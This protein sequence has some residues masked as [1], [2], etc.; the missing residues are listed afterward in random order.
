MIKKSFKFLGNCPCVLERL[1]RKLDSEQ[2][3]QCVPL[4]GKETTLSQHYPDDMIK[5]IV[6]G[7]KQTAAQHDPERFHAF[8]TTSF[9]VMA[10][11]T[12]PDDWVPIFESAQKSFDMTRQRSYVLPTSD[13]TWKMVQQLV[14]WHQLERVQIAYQPTML[15]L[16]LHIPHTHRGWALLYN[17]QTVEVVEED[18][19]DVRH[20]RA[21][22]RKPVNIGIFF[23]GYATPSSHANQPVSARPDGQPLQEPAEDDPQAIVAHNTE[24]ITFPRMPGLSQDVKTL[25]SRLHRNLGHPHNNE[26]K[27]M[28]AMNGIKDQKVYDAV[29]ALTCE[30]CLRVRGPGKPEPA[31]IP[32]D[33]S[34]Q[35]GDVLQIDIVYVRD[36]TST[37]YIFLG[38]IDECTHLHMALHLNDRSPEE[39]HY[40]FS[41]FWARP[42]GFP[43]K[44]KADPDGS[45][46]G[47]FEAAMD[48]AGTYMD[49]IPAEA[50]NKIGLIERHNATL[51][52]LMERTIDAR[53][54]VGPEAMEQAA[55]AACFAKN[56]CTWSS[57]RPPFVAAFGRV[58]RLGMNLLS[59]QHGLV[60]GRTREQ[61]QREADYMRAE[62]QQHLSAMSVDS[63][64]RRALLR[65]STSNQ[66]QELPVG[67]I[68]A[69]WRWTAKSGKKRGGFKLARVLGRGPDNKSIW[70]QAGTNTVK[71]APHQVRPALGFEQW[72][73][74]YD[75]IKALRSA[76]ENLQ[77]GILQDEQL[78]DPP[79]GQEL[80]GF[81]EVQPE[82]QVPPPVGIEDGIPEAHQHEL[83]PV[84]RTPLP[85]PVQQPP[86]IQLE[87]EATQTDPYQQQQTT[88]NMNMSSPTYRQTIIQNQ[89]FG[90]NEAQR[91]RPTV[92][93]PVR[94]RHAS[95]SKTPVRQ[96]R[97]LTPHGERA[98][99]ASV[100]QLPDEPFLEQAHQPS[101][102]QPLA[103]PPSALAPSNPAGG[104]TPPLETPQTEV[105]VV[106]D[107]DDTAGQPASSHGQQ[108]L[109]QSQTA[110]ADDIG[111]QAPTTPEALRLTPAKRTFDEAA[112][113]QTFDVSFLRPFRDERS[114]NSISSTMQ[115]HYVDFDN[116]DV[117][118]MTLMARGFDGSPDV[119]M[120]YSNKSFM[121]AYRQHGDYDGNGD[122]DESDADVKDFR[123]EQKPIPPTLT[124]QEKKAL[125]KEIRWQNIM[126]M[127]EATI[128][129]YVD[130]AKAE[131]RSWLDF[132]S[133]RPISKKEAAKILGD[134]E[135]RKRVLRSRAAFRDK[136]RGVGPLRPKCRIVAVGCSD[137]DLWTL[138]RESATPTRQSEFLVFAIYIAGRNGKMMG[139]PNAVWCLWAGDVKTAFLQGTP[140]QRSMPIFLLPP[141]DGIC[142]RADIFRGADL[143]EVVGNIYGL[144]SAPR[145]WQMHVVKVL[146]QI[147]YQQSSL[148]KML[149]YYYQKFEGESE[150][151]LCAVIIVY[152]DDFL[153]THDSRY[154]RNHL[155]KMFKWGS[156]NELTLENSLDFKGKR[157]SLK[158]DRNNNEYTLK[159]DQEKFISDMKGGTV[160]KKRHK[161]TLDASDLG[162]FRSVSGCLHWLAGQTRPDVAATVSLCSRGAKS[163]YEDL[164]NMYMAVEHLHQTKDHG[165]VLRPVPIDYSTMITTYADSSWANAVGHASQHG[166]LILLSSPKATDVIQP[167][168]LVDWKSSR[169]T[170][171][172][173]STLAA[174]ASAADMSVDR[175]SLINYMLSELLL[176]R[177]AFHIPS[178]D[179]LRMVQATDCRSLYDVLVS[180]NPR[181]EDKRTIVTIRSAQ[182]FLSRDNVFWIPTEIQFADGLTKVS[183]NLMISFYNWLQEPWIQL[184]ECKR[185]VNQQNS[186]SVNFIQHLG[187]MI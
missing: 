124:R 147:G 132:S 167:G 98:Q 32:Q 77:H 160:P 74:N 153:L 1:T 115:D 49:Y 141:A 15:R 145:T 70:L 165:L 68:A 26:L 123:G 24:G 140:E 90:M 183:Q 27:K 42:F 131:E 50:H 71:V 69:Y 54:V 11:N 45:F 182:Q 35:F 162:E 47:S 139:N 78:P 126:R 36:T 152:V 128:Q 121:T 17:D 111:D 146:K 127:D 150:P 60:A 172:C 41:T 21:K 155:L 14:Q 9:Q 18:L 170:R 16:P 177:P 169:S 101:S 173:R 117:D 92:N 84:P 6:Q 58:P 95:W 133:V 23:F 161:E 61:A 44:I 97:A 63:N 110:V 8:S 51:R 75:D 176:N 114:T 164:H 144:A 116:D 25:L 154:D 73:P 5:Q 159:L 76:V 40:K 136:S 184:H 13:T 179:L 104:I 66:L 138:Q 100:R 46:R 149:F 83:I 72:N 120:P 129:Q 106:Q 22:F 105:I 119:Y 81:E 163:T 103:N 142:K 166:A 62:A 185:N 82:V 137:P 186:W 12:T 158:H 4:V 31:G 174:E 67:S 178:C 187:N 59:D 86:Q 180:E 39:V 112:A 33:V 107:D 85:D 113:D 80:P 96:L 134:K 143:L 34:L 52:E 181:A 109:P 79:Q 168:L 10:V 88:I 3:L 30:S 2:L 171:V 151:V 87:E 157:I 135:L 102:V 108:V 65:K 53:A 38:I 37:N 125:D 56:S 94:K 7:I 156:Q 28:L 19:A 130:A 118:G 89:S 55:I 93:V 20:P 99:P 148:D 43:L 175:A 48:E 64:L 29:E 122:S 91:S 57:G